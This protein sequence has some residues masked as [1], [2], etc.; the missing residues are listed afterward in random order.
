M[1]MDGAVPLKGFWKTRPMSRAR[2]CSGQCVT[3]RPAR[4][5]VPASSGNVPATALS[6]VD[7]PD[8]FVPI[9]TTNDPGSIVKSMPASAR[10]SFGVPSKNVLNAL[11]ISN[12][13][14]SLQ[15]FGPQSCQFG[16][17]QRGQ[18]E[19]RRNQL[20]IIGVESPS[21]GNRHE[22]TK[23]DRPHHG[24]D[25]E[26]ADLS[27]SYQRFTNDHT[28]QPPYEHADPHLHV[29]ETLV[30]GQQRARQRVQP[31]AQSQATNG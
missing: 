24:A 26:P 31:I 6:S 28:R 7:F 23:Y 13:A 20:Q 9:T 25:Q 22:Q 1:V 10:T 12:I 15:Y 5:I 3:S 11:R 17:D 27:R 8:P 2:R 30:L 19:G 29:R 16:D 14:W 18:H 4:R 21:Q